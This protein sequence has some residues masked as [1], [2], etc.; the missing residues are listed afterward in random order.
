M[1]EATDAPLGGA[2][3]VI[4]PEAVETTSEAT[5]EQTTGTEETGAADDAGEATEEPAKKVPWFQKRIDEV[6]AAKYEAQRQA[7]YWRGLAEGR[8]K[9]E[10]VQAPQAGPP[11]LEQF[12]DYDAYEQARID[13]AVEQRL[14]KA[15]QEKQ[16]RA[17][18]TTYQEREAAIRASKPD[19][20]T[21]ALNPRLPVTVTMAQAIHESDLGP[22]V[23]YHLGSNPQEAAR[24][25]AL[26]VARQAAEIGR[27]EAALT[28]PPTSNAATV[29]PIPPAPPQTVNAVS[30]GLKKPMEE[31]SYAEFVA[32]REEEEKSR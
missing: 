17:A 2:E 7:D 8:S 21:V 31:M 25:S 29:K 16:Q 18:L 1:T 23:L 30:T 12:D 22:E 26:S 28:K 9:P 27:I 11:Q 13:Y 20:D 5:T 6:T 4:A 14:G 10:A 24:I 15:E 19:F 3:G 32:M